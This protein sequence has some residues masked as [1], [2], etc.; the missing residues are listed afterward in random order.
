MTLTAM[1]TLMA[2]TLAERRA[3]DRRRVPV[4]ADRHRL[5]GKTSRLM[6]NHG[7]GRMR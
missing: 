4:Q 5:S 7:L 3:M 2:M 6:G 1:M